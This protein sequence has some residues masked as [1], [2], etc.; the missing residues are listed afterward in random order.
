MMPF[1]CLFP[2]PVNSPVYH[3]IN[4]TKTWYNAQNYCRT[5]F[6]DLVSIRND[7]Q[8]KAV[9]EMKSHTDPTWIGL[10][11]DSWEWSDGGL[12]GYRDWSGDTPNDGNMA[13]LS[14]NG[15]DTDRQPTN[16]RAYFCYKGIYLNICRLYAN[17][18]PH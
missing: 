2:E 16:E 13:Y 8:N 17:D 9:F 18:I 11:G 6:T 14:T 5:H 10:I 3:Q 4:I 12:S 15:W 1:W 7:E